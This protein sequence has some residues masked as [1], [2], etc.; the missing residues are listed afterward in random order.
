MNVLLIGGSGSL[1][2]NLI[3]KLN[4]EGHRVY[5]LTGSRYKKLSYQKVFERYNFTYDCT[6]L[7][8]IFE[9]IDPDVSIFMGAYDTNFQWKE[10]AAESVRYSAGLMNILMAFAMREKG[11][12]IY[13]SSDEVYDDSYDKDITEG[14]PT[15]PQGVRGMTLAQAEEMCESY[16]RN[17]G[18]DIVTLRLD[19][20][21]GIPKDCR[22][23]TDICT[24]MCLQ[25]LEKNLINIDED[26]TFSLLYEADAIE[27]IYRVVA[28]RTH[29]SSLYNIS[30]S[31]EITQRQLAEM[32]KGSMGEGVWIIPD[33]TVPK[34]RILSNV[35]FNSE[36][37]NPFF[38]EVQVIVQKIVSRMKANRGIFLNEEEEK[39]TLLQR[40]TKK[41]G[42]LIRAVIPF[43]ENLIAFIPFFMLN[44]RAVGSE[45]FANLD[46]YLL[47]V[48]LF[49]IVY[50]QQQATFSAV[51][52]VAGYC[53]RQMYDRSGFEVMLDANTY[54]WI[55]QLFI[56]GLVVGYMRDQIT[57]LKHESEEEREFISQQLLD[58]Q[59]IN[60]SNVRVKDAL[61]TQIV[62]QND[63]VGKIYSITSALDQYS[64]EEV[65]FYAVE[66]LGKLVKSKDV[67]I[68]T[69]ANATYARLFSATSEKARMLGNSIKY[70]EMGEMYET[71]LEQKVFIN[72]KMD[73]RYP[74]MANAIYENGSMQMIIMI[75]GIPWESMTLGQANQLVVISDLIQ[76][77]VLRANRYLSA[78]EDERYVEDTKTLDPEAFTALKNAYLAAQEK[79]LVECTV[80]MVDVDPETFKESGKIL[81]GKLRRTDYIGTQEDGELYVL[82]ANTSRKDTELVLERFRE[83]GFKCHI[84]EE[85]KK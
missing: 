36:F 40:I 85:N 41:A 56:L 52:S 1:I 62:N 70:T 82:L 66:M 22:E 10:E 34:R 8:E 11:R 27:F 48:L 7:N 13:L 46:F 74:L 3:I 9:S 17:R 81:M 83:V 30:S 84:V 57:K 73:E 49:A 69:V 67:A 20:L 63:S 5:L 68:Y 77:A 44:N 39:L 28:S 19:H 76:N 51:L 72:R 37:G 54:V 6:C 4:K 60:S 53:F 43:V 29:K 23:V 33:T 38:C 50:G 42:W 61:S 79:G 47:Y 32:I 31:L 59:D 18:A 75:W 26:S 25:A 21:Y 14:E 58:I 64:P 71:L 15:S 65:L 24:K 2:N 35:L 78:L 80:I 55:A 16:R 12:F 45:Y